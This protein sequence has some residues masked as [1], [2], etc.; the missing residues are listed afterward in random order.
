MK[1]VRLT[2]TN[3][4]PFR[5]DNTI[6]F[7]TDETRNVMIVFGDN[8]RGKTSL[9]NALRWGFY[10]TALGRHSRPIP[11]QNLVNKGATLIDDWRVEVAIQFEANGNTYDLRR[12][13]IRRPHVAT[14]QRPDDFIL[15]VFLSKN[16]APLAGEQVEPEIDQFAPEQISRFFLFDG[17]LL[18]EYESLLIEDSDQGRQIKD[19]IEQVLGVPS[20]IQGR[21]ELQSILRSSTKKQTA[22]LA[23]VQ[24]L[25][26]QADRQKDLTAKQ[27]AYDRDLADLAQKLA[28][29]K[30][31]RIRLEDELD[32]A[33]SILTAKGK[34]DALLSQ[35]D[36]LEKGL[37][38]NQAERHQVLGGAWQDLLEAK[39]GEKQDQLMARQKALTAGLKD[40]GRLQS[41]IE[42]LDK[43][44]KTSECPTCDQQIGPER[45]DEIGQMLGTL[46]AE[47]DRLVDGS[48]ELETI[49]SQLNGIR[50]IRGV[51]A[52]E[53]LA[54]LDRDL[55]VATVNL[56]RAENEIETLRDEIAGHDTAE[57]ARKR[58]LH[59]ES[60]KEE[61]QLQRD[62]LA[63]RKEMEKIRGDLAVLQKSIETLA[64]ARSQRSTLKVATASDLEK[65]FAASVE[66]LRD[67]LRTDV[68]KL[69]TEAFL[70]M[71]TQKGYKGLEI[72]SNYGLSILDDKGHRVP[73]RS[74]GAEQIVALSL[75]DGLN[76]TGRAI[77][78]VVMDT[79]FGRLDLGHRDNI[80]N[81]LPTVTSQFVLLVHSGEV[82]PDTDLATIKPRIGAVYTI[83]E[84]SPTESKLERTSI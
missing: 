22:D 26:S 45:R 46:Q 53:R 57:L 54:A 75:I 70:Q 81:Y 21:T 80:L 7:P 18:Q 39:L 13:A 40:Q 32:A 79:P 43:L 49:A 6:E 35:Q 10:G 28:S 8:M 16:G 78:P 25:R 31:T 55:K 38:N 77:G 82:R 68:E 5:G 64:G 42:N 61:W 52:R 9:L 17:E 37:Q 44:L 63:V 71:T 19:A 12:S 30:D 65:V 1:L 83:R 47:A 33:T 50:S 84:V 69:A 3:F 24:G 15:S 34:L 56:Q 2:A 23:H 14:P 58:S 73:L 74:A 51:R 27:E 72:N 11:L 4:M 29:V 59:K 67:R 60:E 36:T 76:R 48:G 66:R 20:L 41:K 62:I